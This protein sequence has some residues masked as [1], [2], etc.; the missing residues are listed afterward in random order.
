MPKKPTSQAARTQA[1]LDRAREK[2]ILL[3]P[4][5]IPDTW[6]E[7][8]SQIGEVCGGHKPEFYQQWQFI[9]GVGWRRRV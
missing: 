5:A 9:V 3:D 6:T 4:N 8:F 1:K 7:S 2:A